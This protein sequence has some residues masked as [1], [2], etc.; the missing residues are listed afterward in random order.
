MGSEYTHIQTHASIVSIFYRN[1]TKTHLS[2]LF[3]NQIYSDSRQANTLVNIWRHFTFF[4][5]ILFWPRLLL[6]AG[7][8][9]VLISEYKNW[10]TSIKWLKKGSVK[11][12][13]QPLVGGRLYTPISLLSTC[14]NDFPTIIISPK[15]NRKHNSTKILCHLPPRSSAIT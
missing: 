13:N 10:A 2:I 4:L 3:K 15:R 1:H 5:F 9:I 14:T 7:M 11:V 6:K 8:C 12:S